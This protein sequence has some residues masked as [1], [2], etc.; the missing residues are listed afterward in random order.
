[1][2]EEFINKS[3]FSVSVGPMLYCN[4]M[5]LSESVSDDSECHIQVNNFQEKIYNSKWQKERFRL[6]Y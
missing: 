5:F 3:R 6:P 2:G 4:K 1:M